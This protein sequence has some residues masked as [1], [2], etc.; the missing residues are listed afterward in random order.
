MTVGTRAVARVSAEEASAKLPVARL[1]RPPP[2]RFSSLSSGEHAAWVR[3]S[4]R[5][6]TAAAL[7]ANEESGWAVLDARVAQEQADC[8]EWLRSCAVAE[9]PSRYGFLRPEV[10]VEVDAMLKVRTEHAIASYPPY[11]TKTSAIKL[12][13]DADLDPLM[14]SAASNSPSV[15]QAPTVRWELPTTATA[16]FPWPQPRSTLTKA[17]SGDESADEKML[18]IAEWVQRLATWRAASASDL[19]S[20]PM[21]VSADARMAKLAR[22]CKAHIAIASSA[23]AALLV[24]LEGHGLGLDLPL[25]LKP[26]A[27]G[28]YATVFIDKPFSAA[29]CTS[30]QKNS[31]FFRAAL[32][33]ELAM[34]KV[35]SAADVDTSIVAFPEAERLGPVELFRKPPCPPAEAAATANVGDASAARA[36]RAVPDAPVAF[37]YQLFTLGEI[38]ILVRSKHDALVDGRLN[39]ARTGPDASPD[40]AHDF[41]QDTPCSLKVRMEYVGQRCETMTNTEHAR[42]FAYLAVRPASRL[43]LCHVCAFTGRLLHWNLLTLEE[44]VGTGLTGFDAPKRLRELHDVFQA[45]RGQAPGEYLLR[46]AP[47]GGRKLSLWKAGD[48]A[49]EDS[50]ARALSSPRGATL[51]SGDGC[52]R[53]ARVPGQM[54]LREVQVAACRTDRETVTYGHLMWQQRPGAP[55]QAPNTFDPQPETGARDAYPAYQDAYPAYHAQEPQLNATFL[56]GRECEGSKRQKKEGFV[57]Q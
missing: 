53:E 56:G 52:G 48:S 37:T 6:L 1:R 19:S 38:R 26:G 45:L 46:H 55:P 4:A 20:W 21:R 15:Q 35:A 27:F 10:E 18:P 14:M 42:Y 28:S 51:L 7:S 44:L 11:F 40:T 39:S 17:V 2:R 3:L 25:M 24:D 23:F 8:L 36:A 47:G 22:Q 31:K 34:S 13:A 30:R 12:T 41:P 5:M 43:L 32:R 9:S 16:T 57:T 49:E 54:D 29:T 33:S 50:L